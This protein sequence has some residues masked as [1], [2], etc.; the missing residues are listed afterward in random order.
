MVRNIRDY[1]FIVL[2]GRWG[3]VYEKHKMAG[4]LDLITMASAMNKLIVLMPSPKQFDIDR[5]SIFNNGGVP[6]DLTKDG[7][8]FTLEGTHISI[9][10]SK[11]AAASFIDSNQY[12]ALSEALNMIKH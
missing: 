9:Y 4:V 5:E 10:G 8:P 11:N 2:G 3:E 7:M 1:D 6:A 12:Q